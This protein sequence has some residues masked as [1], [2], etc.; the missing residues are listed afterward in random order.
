M[1]LFYQ[2]IASDWCLHINVQTILLG[3]NRCH[4]RV[5]LC[6]LFVLGECDDMFPRIVREGV[7]SVLLDLFVGSARIDG[8]ATIGEVLVKK[9]C[10]YKGGN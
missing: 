7:T 4:R 2:Q 9:L 1:C 8:R 10:A 5:L 3:C 6:A